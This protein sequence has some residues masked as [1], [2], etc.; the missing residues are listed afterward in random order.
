MAG[1]FRILKFGD[2]KPLAIADGTLGVRLISAPK[3]VQRLELRYGVLRSQALTPRESMTFLEK[4][5][6]ET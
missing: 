3:D 1:Q 4:V 6:G 5:L 2:D